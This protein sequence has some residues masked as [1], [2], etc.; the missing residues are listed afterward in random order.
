MSEGTEPPG[1]SGASRDRDSRGWRLP[2]VTGA[3]SPGSSDFAA[4]IVRAVLDARQPQ[5]PPFIG[6]WRR[7][8]STNETA[9]KVALDAG[10]ALAAGSVFIAESQTDGKGRY[11]RTWISPPGGL[12][13]SVLVA[14]AD[15]TRR[16][17]DQL[18]LLPI[19]A[20]VAL[21][22][23]VRRT[24][25]APAVIRWPNDLDCEGRK[26]AGV[27]AET[28]FLRDHPEVAVVGFG[29][30]LGPVAL[31]AAGSDDSRPPGWLPKGVSRVRLARALLASFLEA[32]SLLRDDPAEL[33]ARWESL[34][35][36]A[37]AR[38]C[39]VALDDRTRITGR[40]DGLDPGGGLRVRLEGGATQVIHASEA[41]RIHHPAAPDRK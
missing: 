38:R 30:N 25:G 37:S 19:A 21:A 14:L 9:K 35:P 41:I 36:T 24:A 8:G 33:R 15:S 39:E 26:I 6:V 11:G 32:E 10:G 34:S 29:V 7:A 18:R 4:R 40:T 12:Y 23:A 27:L 17:G 16:R 13:L 3:K 2:A 20:G 22:S 31:P 1:A 28:G 5:P